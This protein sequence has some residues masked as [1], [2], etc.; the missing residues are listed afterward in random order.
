MSTKKVVQP[1]FVLARKTKFH[2]AEALGIARKSDLVLV[3]KGKK[4]LRFVPSQATDA[5]LAAVILGRSGTLRAPALQVGA[6]FV[7][8]FHADAYGELFPS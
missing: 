1:A 7:V 5:E 8:G 3:A 6:T 2:Q 4:L